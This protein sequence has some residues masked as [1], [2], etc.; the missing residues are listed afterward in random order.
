M[1]LSWLAKERQSSTR[2]QDPNQVFILYG[3]HLTNKDVCLAPQCPFSQVLFSFLV[4][5][6]ILAQSIQNKRNLTTDVIHS[7][8]TFQQYGFMKPC[9]CE[10]VFG[11]L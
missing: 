11:V 8:D 9:L 1:R 6:S 3:K 7:P 2:N 5:A 10:S 4:I